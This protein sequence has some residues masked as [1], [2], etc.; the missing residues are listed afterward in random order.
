V[1]LGPAD[2]LPCS[3]RRILVVG[4]SGSGKSTLGR[5]LARRTGIPYTDLDG[6]F[7][8]PGWVERPEFEADVRALAAGPEWITEFGYGKARPHLL[9]RGEV[10]IWLDP[11]RRRVMAQ[12]V[13]RTLRRRLGRTQLWNGNVEPP[14]HTFLTD[15]DHIVRWAWRTYPRSAARVRRVL[16]VRPELPVVRLGSRAEIAAWLSGPAAALG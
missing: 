15:P 11:P 10:L 6:L 3:P 9:P 1:L 5:E 4:C 12:I 14:F 16:A 13:P 7:H 8:G 2:P